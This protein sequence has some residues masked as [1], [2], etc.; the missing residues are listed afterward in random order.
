MQSYRTGNLSLEKQAVLRD[1]DHV[2]VVPLDYF[3]TAILPPLHPRID[4]GVI[5]S[6]LYGSGV[7]SMK[8]DRWA[9]FPQDPEKEA[10]HEDTV[11]APLSLVFDAIVQA[12]EESTGTASK[13]SF[14]QRPATPPTSERTNISCPDA[15]LLL[16]N[17]KSVGKNVKCP[18]HCWED[19]AVSF[20]FKKRDGRSGN[21]RRDVSHILLLNFM[22]LT[23]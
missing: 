17:K 10:S 7:L 1:L 14:V 9:A 20:G 16:V 12:V 4:I 6:R 22:G 11:F 18:V 2:A 13:L 3:N 5:E 15:Y 19:I 8:S 23:S 21:E